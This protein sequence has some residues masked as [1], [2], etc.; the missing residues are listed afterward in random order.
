MND[1]NQATRFYQVHHLSNYKVLPSSSFFADD[2]DLLH[3]N[4]SINR[5]NK[6]INLDMKSHCG[7]K[8]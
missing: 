2:K 1:L 3:F 7:A 4:K 5:I 6:H 8:C